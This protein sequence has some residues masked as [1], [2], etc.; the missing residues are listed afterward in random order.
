MDGGGGAPV[1]NP[2][3]WALPPVT[4][5]GPTICRHLPVDA[6]A[7]KASNKGMKR[8]L[9]ALLLLT[10]AAPA[11]GQDFGKGFQAYARGD[12]ATALAAA[13]TGPMTRRV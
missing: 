8:I 6:T 10:F 13:L 2:R 9:A 1:A 12:F 3:V 5:S 11:W 7:Y 4:I